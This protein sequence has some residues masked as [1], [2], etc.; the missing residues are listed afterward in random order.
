MS[1][2]ADP[3]SPEGRPREDVREAFHTALDEADDMLVAGALLIVEELPRLTRAMLRGDATVVVDAELLADEVQRRCHEVEER[4]FVLLAREA[5]VGGDLRRLV[6]LLRMTTDV[7]RSVTLLEHAVTSL[8]FWDPS[9]LPSSIR[10]QLFELVTAAAEVFSGG[11][12]AWRRRDALAVT[13][14]EELDDRVDRLQDRLLAAAER[15][16]VEPPAAMLILGLLVR[17]FERIADHG[18]AIA[19]DAAFVVTGERLG[20]DAPRAAS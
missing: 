7:D 16:R 1:S 2:F 9:E 8:R 20:L 6:A 14:I 10:E 18:V 11:I 19:R 17:Y 12:A 5:P 3:R 15:D 13:E 4:G